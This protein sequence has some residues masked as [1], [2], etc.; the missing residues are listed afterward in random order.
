VGPGDGLRRLA[1]SVSLPAAVSGFGRQNAC[2]DFVQLLRRRAAD[3]AEKTLY[4][5]VPGV[6][7][8]VEVSY[9]AQDLR[10]RAVGA[11]LAERTRPGDRVVVLTPPG[12]DFATAFFGALYAGCVAVPAWPPEAQRMASTVA[13]LASMVEDSQPSAVL[14]A[15]GAEAQR[16]RIAEFVPALAGLP[17][18]AVG[19]VA[20][21]QAA[22][23][24]EPSLGG[25]A[26]AAIQYTS[27]S[28]ASPKGVM[29]TH[30]NLLANC[31]AVMRLF[32]E[33]PDTR[34]VIW[35]PPYHDM[36]LIGGVL[37]PV[38]VAGTCALMAPHSFLMRPHRW[39]RMMS[40]FGA[41]TSGAPGFAF[42]LCVDRV[43]A[44]Q[45][46]DVDLSG[47]RVAFCGA[48]RVRPATIDRFTRAFEPYG[49]DRRAFFPCYGLAESTLIVSGGP[50]DTPPRVR[51]YDPA[52]LDAGQASEREGGARLVGCGLPDPEA[53]LEIVDPAARRAL[54]RGQIGEVW[55]TSRSV[56]GG[57][58]RRAEETA[59][60][61]GA[62][63]PGRSERFLRTGD[64]GFLDAEGELVITGRLKEL[65]KISGRG[66]YPQDF[67]ATALTSHPGVRGEAAAFAV[68]GE[69]GERL[70]LVV[71]ARSAEAE[72]VR[73]AVREAIARVHDVG[74]E[75]VVTGA[76]LPSTLSGKLQRLQCRRLYVEGGFAAK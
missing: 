65:I 66:H 2:P 19:E 16:S 40:E 54:G 71:R 58:W 17:W 52:A 3:Y 25:D 47:W 14:V 39:L 24:R 43:R 29:L 18:I 37:S 50:M 56:A 27:G 44:E 64:L 74:A 62:Q 21:E 57:Y 38:Y 60:V 9:G 72:A 1:A 28:T 70:V 26:L 31:D 67:E 68:E 13:R 59:E 41:T 32:G 33:G 5:F 46:E 30:G 34:G 35:L 4:T 76:A 36:G 20:D 73:V 15:Q 61:F 42:D 45:L 10:A 55:V 49:F 12:A 48:E 53:V 69:D 8:N 22:G 51:S 11:A 6:G 7:A 23:W 75:V 63:L